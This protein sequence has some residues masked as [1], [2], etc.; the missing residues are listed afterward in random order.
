MFAS[1][2]HHDQW[3][4]NKLSAPGAFLF[5]VVGAVLWLIGLVDVVAHTSQNATLFGIYSIPYAI[6]IFVYAAA[7]AFW[8]ALIFRGNSAS[9]IH[10]A[11]G[12]AQKK[13]FVGVLVLIAFIALVASMFLWQR[14]SQLPML[15]MAMF[16]LGVL[17]VISVVF[18][19]VSDTKAQLWRKI[20]MLTI[21]AFLLV[22][23]LMQLAARAGV[24]PFENLSG[25][26]TPFG[27]VYQNKEG[28]GY[29]VTNRYGWYA[30]GDR[31]F[32]KRRII[33]TGD[34]IVQGLQVMPNENVGKK[35]GELI[36]NQNAQV[37]TLGFNGYGASLYADNKL[38]PFTM[39]QFQPT[40]VVVFFHPVND[41]QPPQPQKG[42]IRLRVGSSGEV[43]VVDEDALKRHSLQH[44][45]IRAYDP[46]N[47]MQTLQSHLFTVQ[48]LHKWVGYKYVYRE[49][50]DMGIPPTFPSYT[51]GTDDTHPFGANTFAF[52]RGQNDDAQLAFKLATGQL[53]QFKETLEPLGIQMKLV[54]IPYFPQAFFETQNG[55]AWS[56]EFGKYDL[57][58]PEK[59]LGKFA[60]ENNIP[61][62]PMGDYMQKSG[63]TIDQIKSMFFKN[64]KGHFT[65]EGHAYFAQ[66]V[67]TCL[68][69]ASKACP[70]TP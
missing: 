3:L 61:F 31:V 6:F 19:K 70:H 66:A 20:A 56:N 48:L 26:H 25:L 55:A 32:A 41:L 34:S 12:V 67:Y 42:I 46:L 68:Y 38:A 69:Q 23:F 21:G 65:K 49:Y 16:A 22:E 59:E 33:V 47:P 36:A 13:P 35:L 54:T 45:A 37:F 17:I 64:G 2:T 52:E 15:E 5:S 30:S 14:W 24:L 4:Q 43:K 10:R 39:L 60:R 7:F 62:L 8:V 27:R 11:I 50:G 29:G 51:D 18:G 44:L 57:L 9:I 1:P 40:E 28:F 63:A 58:A 53:K